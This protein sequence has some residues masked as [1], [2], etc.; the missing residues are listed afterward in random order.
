MSSP[1]EGVK[2]S[3][4]YIITARPTSVT[5][6]AWLMIVGAFAN[7]T[8]VPATHEDLGWPLTIAIC[9]AIFGIQ[10]APPIG[11]LAGRNWARWWFFILAPV[12]VV[13]ASLTGD[14]PRAII[15][16]VWWLTGLFFLTRVDCVAYFR[17][18]VRSEF[19]FKIEERPMST[20]TN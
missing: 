12:I 2:P 7:F 9:L 19:G 3:E 6:I 8:A 11:L 20:K 16:G 18:A 5:V 1:A 4:K 13:L 14:V 10:L 15:S 17:H